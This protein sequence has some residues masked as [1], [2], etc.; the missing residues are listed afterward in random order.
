MNQPQIK[1]G[2]DCRLLLL[3]CALLITGCVADVAEPKKPSPRAN[4]LEQI[5]FESF[6]KRDVLRAAKLRALKGTK[7][8]GKRI[9]AI[10]QAGAEA[11]TES[12]KRVADAL[13]KRLDELP[14]DDQAAF[15]AVIEELAK[16][17][18]RAGK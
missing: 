1:R 14:Q 12:W 6:Q 7:Y 8:D 16:A 10:E 4:T 18:E 13:A 15:D 11:S 5:A 3:V 2:I 17:A 9:Q